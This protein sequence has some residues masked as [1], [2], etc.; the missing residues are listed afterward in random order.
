MT[1]VLQRQPNAFCL[2]C[3]CHAVHLCAVAAAKTLTD[4]VEQLLRDVVYHFEY[5]PKRRAALLDFQ[6]AEGCDY[7]QLIKPAS[8]RW[9]SLEACAN[10]VLEQWDALL[11]FFT[12]CPSAKTDKAIWIKERLEKPSTKIYLNFLSAVLPIFNN[13]NKQ[14]QREGIEIHNLLDRQ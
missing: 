12:H 9:L 13:F 3:P 10:R 6:A 14:F 11:A 7:H 4:D 2:H 5:S 1:R 8:T